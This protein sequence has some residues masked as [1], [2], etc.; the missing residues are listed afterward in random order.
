MT[1]VQ[2]KQDIGSL[3]ANEPIKWLAISASYILQDDCRLDASAYSIEKFDALQ[4][5]NSCKQ[6][7]SN[8]G[9]LCGTI[10]HPVQNQARSNFKRIYTH[11]DHGDPYVGSR[12][13]FFFPLRPEKFLSRAFPKLQEL[14]VPEGWLLLSRSGTVGNILYCS[15]KLA[16]YL[17]T[18][19][20]IRIEPARIPAGYLYAF[21]ACRYGQPLLINSTYGS[22]VSELEPKHIAAL[23]VPIAS[24]EIQQK[25]HNLI[26]EAYRLRDHANDLLD[27]ADRM[28][29]EALGLD[30]FD[31]KDVEYLG[32]KGDPKA[33]T[34]TAVELGGRFDASN[35]VPIA[36]SVLHKL[37]KCRIPLSRLGNSCVSIF[38]PA[39]FKR[40]YVE[41]NQGCDLSDSFADCSD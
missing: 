16:R 10:W 2:T 33:F 18:D 40:N 23:P 37:E 38:I 12:E 9:S 5:I 11:R 4:K 7:K 15:K 28:L 25:I 24:N 20:A 17:I 29:H 21:L 41:V 34:I 32:A 31:E 39:R 22:T 19:H 14:R 8:L 26:I 30:P 27:Q 1:R 6:I 35:H 3:I 13:M 36:R